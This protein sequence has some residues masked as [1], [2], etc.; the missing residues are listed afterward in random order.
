V[1]DLPAAPFFGSD[2]LPQFQQYPTLYGFSPS[3]IPKPSDW[4]N[5]EVTGYWFLDAA[6]DWVPPADLMAFLQAGPPPVYIGFGSMGSRKPEETADLVLQAIARTGQRAILL[7]GWGGLSKAD[8]PETV[9]MVESVPHSWLFS[10][11]AA[12][13]HHGGAGTTA[14]GLRAGVPSIVIPFFGDQPFWGQRVAKLGVGPEP[15]PRKQL[16]VERLAQA[17]RTAVTDRGMIRRAA[18][19]GAKIQAEDGVANAVAI[20]YT[21]CILSRNWRL[22]GFGLELCRICPRSSQW[23]GRSLVQKNVWRICDLL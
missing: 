6:T 21:R 22:Y 14:A 16:T 10:Q 5:T 7:S 3:V 20:S 13:V 18:D 23:G 1:F 9:F 15:I 19:L 11:V 2:N 8:L 12:V 17:I 4:H